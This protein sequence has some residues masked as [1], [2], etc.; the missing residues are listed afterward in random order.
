MSEK[1]TGWTP[2][3]LLGGVLMVCMGVVWAR[4]EQAPP[5]P[6]TERAS[7]DVKPPKSARPPK[8]PV[9][10][11]APPTP[12]VRDGDGVSGGVSGGIAGGVIALV[13]SVEA[14]DAVA[15]GRTAKAQAELKTQRGRMGATEEGRKI[16]QETEHSK[17]QEIERRIRYAEKRFSKDGVNGLL[18]DRGRTYLKM[19]PPDEIE[20]HPGTSEIWLYGG[21]G[22][23]VEF[24]GAG[25]LKK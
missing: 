3:W 21:S 14:V 4:T 6:A 1:R 20:S 2:A 15:A 24:D 7:K 8:P 25:R 19:G 12:P 16:Q 18:T 9:P 11:D 22:R 17:E 23:V 13:P 10:P 5:P